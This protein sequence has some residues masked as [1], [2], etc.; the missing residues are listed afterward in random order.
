[1]IE[2]DRSRFLPVKTTDDLLLVRSDVYDVDER[3]RL[4]ARSDRLPS[5]N[6]DRK[7]YATIDDFSARISATPSLIRARSLEVNGDWYYEEGG[8]V[9]GNAGLGGAANGGPTRPAGTVLG[10]AQ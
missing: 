5:V 4:R 8:R 3:C 10:A 1:A 6:L 7:F 9:L 2:V